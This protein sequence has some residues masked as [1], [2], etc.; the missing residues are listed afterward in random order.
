[1]LMGVLG[2]GSRAGNNEVHWFSRVVV[3]VVGLLVMVV[4]AVM[5]CTGRDEDSG[6]NMES[7][8]LAEKW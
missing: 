1:M 4:V 7:E 2:S 5:V 6:G 8:W 3:V